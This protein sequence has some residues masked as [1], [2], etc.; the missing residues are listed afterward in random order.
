VL[1]GDEQGPISSEQLQR[2]H[3]P[4]SMDCDKLHYG[5]PCF[6]DSVTRPTRQWHP[7]FKSPLS[8]RI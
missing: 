6:T 2:R 4:L 7:W 1:Q 5:Q 3:R 8:G